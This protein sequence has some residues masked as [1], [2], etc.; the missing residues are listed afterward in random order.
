MG[1]Y[2]ADVSNGPC[3]ACPANSVATQT[4]LTVCPC[5]Q[6]YYRA[7]NEWANVSCTRE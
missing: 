5:M 1:T 7:P 4:G 2:S 3:E 6:D